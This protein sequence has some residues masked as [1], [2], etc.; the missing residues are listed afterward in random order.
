VRTEEVLVQLIF[1]NQLLFCGIFGALGGVVHSLDLSTEIN[2]YGMISK[3][4][5]SASAGILLF[6]STYG[7][8]MMTPSLRIAAAIVS[9]FYGSALFRYLAKLYLR[10]TPGMSAIGKSIAREAEAV[11]EE[12]DRRAGEDKDAEGHHT[13]RKSTPKEAHKPTTKPKRGGTE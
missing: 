3:V 6:F 4:I 12:E 11:V 7:I 9:G 5:I 1:S 8:E 10:Q 2:V 13:A